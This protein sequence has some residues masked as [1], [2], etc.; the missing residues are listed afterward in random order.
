MSNLA[1]I[2]TGPKEN[3]FLNSPAMSKRGN[4]VTYS[5]PVLN[6]NSAPRLVDTENVE[7]FFT[8]SGALLPQERQQQFPQ[9]EAPLP[10]GVLPL[11]PLL[12]VLQLQQRGM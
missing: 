5:L 8:A 1:P 6:P 4:T 12:Q 9:P 2:S 3:T 10:Q 11:S 7:S